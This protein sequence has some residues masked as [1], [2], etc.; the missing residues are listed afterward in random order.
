M[1]FNPADPGNQALL[2]HVR[3]PGWTSPHPL[4]HYDL[5]VIGGGTAGLV[6]AAGAAGL[7]ATVALIERDRLG[8]DCLNTGCVPSKTLLAS[9]HAAAAIARGAALG[10]HATLDAVDFGAVMARVR[11][12]RAAIAPH[13]SAARFAGLG[14]HVFFGAAAFASPSSVE[15]QRRAA[16]VLQGGHRHRRATGHPRHRRPA[17]RGRR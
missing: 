7:G 3:P 1:A 13:D 17:R 9:A 14:V 2:S 8:G 6:T 16:V 11:A 4:P 12:T 15:R 5:V 10:V